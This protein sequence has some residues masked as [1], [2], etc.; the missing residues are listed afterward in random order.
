MS[1][2]KEKEKIGQCNLSTGLIAKLLM[3][4]WKAERELTKNFLI[5]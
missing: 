5:L 4:V 2:K 1:L 3:S